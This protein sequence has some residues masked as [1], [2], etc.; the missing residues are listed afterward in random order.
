MRD[1]VIGCAVGF[2]DGVREC[3][4]QAIGANYYTLCDDKAHMKIERAIILYVYCIG[5][6]H[7]ANTEYSARAMP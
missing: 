1:I 3:G 2:G 5:E 7:M 6:E 4:C